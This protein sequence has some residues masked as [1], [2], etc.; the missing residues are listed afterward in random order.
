VNLGGGQSTGSSSLYV[1]VFSKVIRKSRNT[2]PGRLAVPPDVCAGG[3]LALSVNSALR[4]TW[5]DSVGFFCDGAGLCV[6]TLTVTNLPQP[7]SMI[8]APQVPAALTLSQPLRSSFRVSSRTANP[9]RTAVAALNNNA[10][11]CHGDRF[12]SSDC[13]AL[14]FRRIQLREIKLPD[15][16]FMLTIWSAKNVPCASGI[17]S[18]AEYCRRRTQTKE[19]R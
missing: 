12:F 17:A 6:G 5:G 4:G 13:L 1:I 10:L 19:K 7:P 8:M 11:V 16:D 2:R 14:H 15:L 3:C 18:M 9:C